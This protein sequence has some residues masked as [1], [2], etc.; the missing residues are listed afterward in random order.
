MISSKLIHKISLA[1]MLVVFAGTAMAADPPS[2]K[3]GAVEGPA[4]VV[5]ARRHRETLTRGLATTSGQLRWRLTTS[6]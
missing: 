3:A 5:L 1:A 2:A 6:R 4:C